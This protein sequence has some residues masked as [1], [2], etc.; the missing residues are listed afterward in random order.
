MMAYEVTSHNIRISDSYEVSKHGFDAIL[1][2][3]KHRHPD[4][5]V[6]HRSRWSL[7]A[8]WAVHNALYSLGIAREHTKD[9]DLNYPLPWY[10]IL[11]YWL[12]GSF[13]WIFIK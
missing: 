3:L 4:C 2:D 11:F 5:E 7:K 12:A 13:L 6:W 9:V 8:E 10:A 1:D